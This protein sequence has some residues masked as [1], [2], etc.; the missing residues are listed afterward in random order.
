LSVVNQADAG[1]GNTDKQKSDQNAL[2]LTTREVV[3]EAS[4]H[5]STVD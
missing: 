4:G 1:H 3:Q 2:Q 5:D